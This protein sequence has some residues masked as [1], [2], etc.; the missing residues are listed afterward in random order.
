MTQSGYYASRLSGERLRLVYGIAPA[1]VRRYL[2]AEIEFALGCLPRGGA[3]LELGC[4][5]GRVLMPLAA[6]AGLAIGVDTARESLALGRRLAADGPACELLPMDAAA[7]GF[8]AETFDL[9]VCVQNGICAFGADREI[10]VKEAV[11]V[12][13][14]GGAALFS[15]YA[16][17]FWPHRLAWFEAQAAAGL[18]GPIDYERTRDGVIACTDGFR[19]GA[20]AP[21]E[22]LALCARAGAGA[23]CRIAEVESSSVFCVIE[24]P[25]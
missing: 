11:R 8:R 9:V 22:L 16:A 18:L 15:T 14:P 19:A 12:T 7:L 20:L 25:A 17:S 13:R 2:E 4:G 10:L 24:R 5:Y 23:A 3:V 6:K 1:R 21:G